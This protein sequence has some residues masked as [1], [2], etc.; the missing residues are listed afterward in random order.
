LLISV[1]S[2][3]SSAEILASSP[4]GKLATTGSVSI[5]GVTAPTGTAVFSGDS[6]S[7]Q[8][9][10]ALITFRAGGRVVL[11]Q[12]AA[13]TFSQAGERLVVHADK[14]VIGF[15]FVPGEDVSIQAGTYEFVASA[16]ERAHTGEVTLAENSSV[17]MSLASGTFSALDTASGARFDVLPESAPE[18]LP[19]QQAGKGSLTKGGNTFTD[20][21]A[22]WAADSLKGGTITVNGEKHKIVSNTPMMIKIL[23][24]WHLNTGT[25]GYSVATAAA[26]AAAAAGVGLSVGAKVGIVI[27][28][29]AA[30]GAG[31]GIWQVTKSAK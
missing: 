17:V 15:N 24:T 6:V 7:T 29:A 18:P 21:T 23:G 12:H 1:T 9:S 5:G 14:G 11:A 13:A 26:A 22:N 20:Q 25:Y 3:F 10:A 16:P 19:Q 30:A 4:I 31:V 2:P 27:A 28:F 8:E